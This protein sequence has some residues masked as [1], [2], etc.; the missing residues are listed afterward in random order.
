M[1]VQYLKKARG[2]LRAVATPS[3]PLRQSDE[4]YEVPVGVDVFDRAGERVFHAEIRMWL[5]AKA[6]PA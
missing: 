1:T 3:V 6:A 4:P 5:S 2:T